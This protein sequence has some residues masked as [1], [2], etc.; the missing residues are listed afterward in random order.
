MCR[1]YR[2][3]GK[4]KIG[5]VKKKLGKLHYL[6]L[7]DDGREWKRH[8]NQISKIG[9]KIKNKSQNNQNMQEEDDEYYYIDPGDQIQVI[10]K[11]SDNMSLLNETI[12]SFNKY[13]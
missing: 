10:N 3:K 11:Q 12:Y 8:I 13:K 7:L 5:R 2:G 4:W 1:N 9:E 6:I